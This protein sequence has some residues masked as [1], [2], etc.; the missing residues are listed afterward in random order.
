L[1]SKKLEEASGILGLEGCPLFASPNF[2]IQEFQTFTDA[3][4]AVFPGCPDLR[5]G[6]LY[7]NDNTGHGVDIDEE[8]AK[9]YPCKSTIVEWSQARRSDGSLNAP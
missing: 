5:D 3:T 1:R 2:G 7:P 8:E 4:R 9:K 6:Y